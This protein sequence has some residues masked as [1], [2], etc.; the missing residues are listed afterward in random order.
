MTDP[1][2]GVFV[3]D[4]SSAMAARA[5]SLGATIVASAPHTVAS[6]VGVC[7]EVVDGR[8]LAR[9]PDWPPAAAFRVEFDPARL[10]G[11]SRSPLVKAAGSP[12]GV[13]LDA[14]AGFGGDAMAFAVAGWTVIAIER[15]PWIHWLLEEGLAAAREDPR[16]GEAASRVLLRRA[17]AAEVLEAL[18]RGGS[19]ISATFDAWLGAPID[20]VLL[21]PMFPAEARGKRALPPK[22][23]QLLR[24]MAGEDPEAATLL[25]LARRVCT[26]RVV[27]KRPPWAEPLRT[28]IESTR[29]TKLLRIDSYRPER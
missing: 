17:D 14:T 18:R 8:L 6:S 19:P 5:A 27:V 28:G 11:A 25:D 15:D 20:V 29:E 22:P 16:L 7:L 21:D 24:A 9:L 3:G 13:L 1:V 4:P 26:R 12:P 23:A 10:A 2:L